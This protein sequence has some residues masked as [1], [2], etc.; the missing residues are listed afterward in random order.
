MRA[1][2][3]VPSYNS[4]VTI[5]HCLKAIEDQK[6]VHSYEIVVVDSSNDGTGD[7]IESSFPGVK[8]IRMPQR[9][10]PG[11]ARNLGIEISQ[12]EILAF[13]DADCIPESLWLDKMISQHE[14]GRYAAVGGSVFNG[15]PFHPVAWAGYLL[16][17][18]ERLPKLPKR[19]VDLLPT[20]NVS[21]TRSAFER[22]GL[23][24]TN[25]WPSEDHIFSWKLVQGGESLLFNPGIRVRHIFRTGLRS[26]LQHQV[27]LGRASATARRQVDLPHRWLV[28][29]PLRFFVS[30]VRLILLEARLGRW[31]LVN[32]LRFNLL[33]PLCLSGLIAW[34]IG[35]CLD[36]KSSDELASPLEK[37]AFPET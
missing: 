37:K 16:E 17:F 4:R 11:L 10:L 30:M 2:V 7:L 29:H 23:F 9:T 31:D 25:L 14:S 15:L 24:P 34:G 22:H 27:R 5:A 13:T 1:S 12:G 18:S 19:E 26:F 35:F 36:H 33:L 32:F 6:T 21:V 28:D 3:I 8:L 20:C